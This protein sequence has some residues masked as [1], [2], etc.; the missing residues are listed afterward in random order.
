[1]DYE[2]TELKYIE[3]AVERGKTMQYGLIHYLSEVVFKPA[4]E[5]KEVN[6]EECL[7]ARF[8]KEDEEIRIFRKNESLVAKHIKDI[9][10]QS[11]SEIVFYNL[12]NA[13][14]KMGRKVGVKEYY[15]KDEDGQAIVTLTRLC[16]VEN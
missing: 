3:E 7:E 5:I 13:F 4:D 14:R 10:P 1:M 16:K 2:V 12:D 15:K 8:F 9:G 11:D 6:L